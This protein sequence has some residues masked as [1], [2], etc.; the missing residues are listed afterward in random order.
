M[1]CTEETGTLKR[2]LTEL[3][4]NGRGWRLYLNYGYALFA[5]LGQR[6][7]DIECGDPR[8]DNEV[9]WLK[10]L[11]ACETDVLPPPELV[12]SIADWQLP[13]HRLD[14]LPPM[15]LRTAWQACVAVQYRD[16]C[17][18]E[19]IETELNPLAQWFFLSTAHQTI[20][21]GQLKAGWDNLLRLRRESVGVEAKKLGLDDWPP[22]VRQYESG[23]Y[24][25]VAL[26]YA[27]QLQEEGAAM[28]HCVGSYADRC[29]MEPLRIFSVRYKKTGA[30]VAT[31]SL[32]ETKPGF[33]HFD[34]LKG[35]LNAEVDSRISQEADALLRIM[36]Q[37]S[38]QD[39]KTRQFLDFIH[40]LARDFDE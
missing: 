34:Q 2:H 18:Q 11:Q 15:F 28:A 1:I 35:P 31:L 12:R 39:A 26:S 16:E 13:G 21:A 27:H 38:R 3:G 19:F 20:D 10:I 29:R 5:P 7:C 14:Q 6:W 37:I 33:W 4:V 8:G 17:L 25:F 23:A 32:R 36:N 22:I 30:R 24:R 9:A 40:S